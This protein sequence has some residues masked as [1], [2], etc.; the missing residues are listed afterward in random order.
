MT[1]AELEEKSARWRA[2]SCGRA[3]GRSGAPVVALDGLPQAAS[4]S[5]RRGFERCLLTS[6]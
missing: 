4:S 1:D 3:D 5:R 6:V 2:G